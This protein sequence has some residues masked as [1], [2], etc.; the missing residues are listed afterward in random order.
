[1]K[2]YM[3]AFVSVKNYEEFAHSYL[4]KA[5]PIVKRYGGITL[6]VDD[7][8]EYIEGVLPAGRL[9]LIEFDSKQKALGFYND[10]AYQPLKKWRQG[11]STSEAVIF[12]SGL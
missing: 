4:S 2:A 3:L 6:A 12:E 10:P 7:T 1:M 11:V 8:P 5:V 9:V